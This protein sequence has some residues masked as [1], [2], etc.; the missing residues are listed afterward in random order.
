MWIFYR[1]LEWVRWI[2]GMVPRS[3]VVSPVLYRVVHYTFWVLLI[4]LAAYFSNE[5]RSVLGPKGRMLHIPAWLDRVWWGAMLVLIYAMIR[6][7]LYLMQ[8]MGIQE[9]SDFPDIESDWQ[10][11]LTALERERLYIDD[12][13]L[14]LV[15]GLTPQQ[16]QSALETASNIEWQVIAPP[17]TRSSA[18][19][20]AYATDQMVLVCCTGV[21]TTN[22]QQGKVSVEAEQ[23]V[24][25]GTMKK[26]PASV[27]GTRR[28]ENIDAV[29]AQARSTTGTR[30]AAAPVSPGGTDP[31]PPRPAQ[32]SMGGFFGTIAPGGLRKAMATFTAMNS[33]SVKGFGK[34]RLT[35]ITELER[36]VGMRRMQ[37]LCELIRSARHPFCGINGLLQ[38]YPFS[39]ATDVEYAKR[40]APAI[41]D[42]L[43][44]VHE[45]LQLQFPVVAV[46]TELDSVSGIREFLLRVE[47]LQPGLRMSRAGSRFAAG[48]VVNDSNAQWIIDRAMQWFRGWIYTAFSYDIDSRDNQK[49]FQMMCE[50]SQRRNALVAL[51]R[52][53][54]YG[55]VQP[56]IRLYGAYFTAT[57]RSTTEQ[58]FIRGVLDKLPES[59]SDVAWTPQ[60]VRSQKRSRLIAGILYSGAAVMVATTVWIYFHLIDR[61]DVG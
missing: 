23:P 48:A 26:P 45:T 30:A 60:L 5:I 35:P 33:S 21:G 53:S 7:V 15:N 42:D 19:I 55:V 4:L 17:L 18:V 24:G 27:T 31:A 1:V 28:V 61:N 22:C 2:F 44:V 25:S 14:F 38:A 52:D 36:A 56:N 11:I 54:I 46:I 12:L 58:G 59:Q 49:L 3:A 37:H 10:E 16:E 43:V 40:L 8:V 50:V 9:E 32:S 57:G 13:P 34:K 6:V 41:R 39:W 47:R 20:R 29:V 51:L